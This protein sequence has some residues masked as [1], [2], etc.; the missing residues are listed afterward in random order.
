MGIGKI[1]RRILG[2][3]SLLLLSLKNKL[4]PA[5]Q[6]R[7]FSGTDIGQLEKSLRR[8]ARLLY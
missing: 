6:G 3:N 5:K 1:S 7:K 2:A 8:M 4:T